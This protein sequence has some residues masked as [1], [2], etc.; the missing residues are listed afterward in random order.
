MEGPRWWMGPLLTQIRKPSSASS[1]SESRCAEIICSG[2]TALNIASGCLIE[3]LRGL[4]LSTK[5]SSSYR[6]AW[7]QN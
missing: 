4:T 1:L 6:N 7:L 5:S 3:P 2:S